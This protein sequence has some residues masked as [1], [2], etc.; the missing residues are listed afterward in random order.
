MWAPLVVVVVVGVGMK[1]LEQLKTYNTDPITEPQTLTPPATPCKDSKQSVLTTQMKGTKRKLTYGTPNQKKN[2][3]NHRQSVQPERKLNGVSPARGNITDVCDARQGSS[4]SDAAHVEPEKV[5]D[6]CATSDATVATGVD[7]DG[8]RREEPGPMPVFVLEENDRSTADSLLH[9]D[10]CVREFATE[11]L[12]AFM[13]SHERYMSD[14][15]IPGDSRELERIL[16]DLRNLFKSSSQD[17]FRFVSLHGNHVHVI[18]TCT[19]SNQV[20]R[21]AWLK[22]SPTICKTISKRYRKRVFA[23][24]LT[25]CDW[26]GV[27]R[28]FTTNGHVPQDVQSRGQYGRLCLR[29]KN[30]L[31]REDIKLLE[32]AQ[33]YTHARIK[34]M[35]TL[36]KDHSSMANLMSAVKELMADLNSQPNKRM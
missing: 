27:A 34:A 30:I 4:T 15:C 8:C 19:Y 6:G 31:E 29:L 7:S 16:S 14:V 2:H 24:D 10:Q 20:C 11:A 25:V 21:C 23:T 9:Y 36:P 26:E 22:S 12:V 28:Y 3:K 35:G 17:Q 5:E 18:H 1:F 13:G 32:K 33:W